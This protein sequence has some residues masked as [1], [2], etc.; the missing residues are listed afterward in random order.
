MD[1]LVYHKLEKFPSPEEIIGLIN[2]HPPALLFDSALTGHSKNRFSYALISPTHVWSGD[3]NPFTWLKFELAGPCG[4]SGAF[5]FCG[6][7]AGYVSYEAATFLKPLTHLKL[8]TSPI[9]LFWFAKFDCVL[10]LDHENRQATL[11]HDPASKAPR[12]WMEWLTGK[13]PQHLSLV[14]KL[15]HQPR[16]EDYAQKIKIIQ[17][18]LKA[19]DI[20]QVNL[21]ERFEA[22]YA[23][24]P[25]ALY[26]ALR[27][28]SAAPFG[29]FLNAG[30]FQV[31]SASPECLLEFNPDEIATYPI[32]GTRPRHENQEEDLRLKNELARSEKD[33]AELL[34]IVDL[35]RNDL[36]KVCEFGSVQVRDLGE[37]E[38]FAQVHHR[39]AKITGKPR[40]GVTAP[41]AL[42]AL[43]PGGSVTGAPKKRAM[44]IIAELEETPRSVYTGALGYF[45]NNGQAQFNLPI[46]T[47]IK[48]GD[49][50]F[51][52]AGGGIVADS[53]AKAEFDELLTKASG[54]VK[55]VTE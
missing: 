48:K 15:T 40:P 30:E 31:L 36:G 42:A 46:R 52:N 22:N 32:K 43:F 25:G 3:H 33:A 45:G 28:E 27:E 16:F 19:G 54:M 53:E 10:V 44:E 34:M 12:L 35:E 26:Q 2:D 21:T 51:F 11:A 6:G 29:A 49:Q 20:Y 55:A 23:G 47:L 39:V 4:L 50:V 8:K 17:D 18:Y 13:K 9:P 24:P 14:G 38:S 5:P 7:L 37:T 41:E 1:A